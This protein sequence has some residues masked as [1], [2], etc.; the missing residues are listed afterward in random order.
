MDRLLTV[1]GLVFLFGVCLA[2]GQ[3]LAAPDQGGDPRPRGEMRRDRTGDGRS[4]RDLDRRGDRRDSF[5][6]DRFRDRHGT[7]TGGRIKWLDD[8]NQNGILDRHE[9]PGLAGDPRFFTDQPGVIGGG[10]FFPGHTFRRHYSWLDDWD[11]D[12]IPNR[13]DRFDDSR[14]FPDG[15]SGVTRDINPY[16]IRDGRGGPFDRRGRRDPRFRSPSNPYVS[17]SP[18]PYRSTSPN[19]YVR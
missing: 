11:Q 18:N 4:G 9:A 16:V 15:I 12:G 10:G 13:R 19:P 14:A 17:P 2:P 7:F 8:W 5:D 1:R 6:R 3:A